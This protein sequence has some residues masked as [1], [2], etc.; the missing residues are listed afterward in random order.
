MLSALHEDAERLNVSTSAQKEQPVE[1]KNDSVA[2][3]N[4]QIVDDDSK[5]QK[6]EESAEAA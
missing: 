3:T 6:E 4:T 1:Q 2:V 5:I